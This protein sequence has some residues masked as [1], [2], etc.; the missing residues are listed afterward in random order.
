MADPAGGGAPLLVLDHVPPAPGDEAPLS[1]VRGRSVSSFRPVPET[2]YWVL[3]ATLSRGTSVT[4][5]ESHGDEVLYVL[6]GELEVAGSRC[7]EASALVVESGA[8]ATVTALR[9]VDVVHIGT[10]RA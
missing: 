6:S 9:E 2:I 5:S 4:W 8:P 10:M 7:S 1:R 3:R